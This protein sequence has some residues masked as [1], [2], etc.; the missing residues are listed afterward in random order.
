M[1]KF[2][3]SPL[4]YIGGKYSLLEDILSKTPSDVDVFIDLFTGGL[5]VGINVN[6]KQIIANDKNTYLIDL[7]KFLKET[8]TDDLIFKIKSVIQKY[9]L[10]KENTEGYNLLREEYNNTHSS[11][12]LFVLTCF[13]F[14]HQ[15]RFNNHFSFNT[16]FGKNRSSYNPRIESNLISFCNLLKKKNISLSTYDFRDFPFM[17]FANRN[18]V[19]YCDPPYLITTGS[20]NDGKRGFGDWT[21]KEDD[22]LL[23]LL[24]YLHDQGIVFFLSNVLSHKGFENTKLKTWSSKYKVY[25]LNKSYLNCN[26]HLKNK[27]EETDEVLVTNYETGNQELSN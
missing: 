4:N 15:I 6:A 3:K 20:Y 11:L 21:Q 17:E 7:F 16:P 19:V 2:C 5:N 13:S 1:N 27:G 18:T 10:S 14:N 24:D 25:H 12:L 26:Y 23:N 8:P 9:E 22:D